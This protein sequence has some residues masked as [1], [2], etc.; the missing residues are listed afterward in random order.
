MAL[1]KEMNE[2]MEKLTNMEMDSNLEKEDVE[3]AEILMNLHAEG[4]Y[5]L[6]GLLKGCGGDIQKMAMVLINYNNRSDPEK[7]EINQYMKVIEQARKNSDAFLAQK[8]QEGL[9]KEEGMHLLTVDHLY[10]LAAEC[11]SSIAAS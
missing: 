7:E 2:I 4:A 9:S 5:E 8:M 3:A 6:R 10:A 1:I 11:T